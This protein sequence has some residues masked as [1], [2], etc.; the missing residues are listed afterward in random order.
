[1]HPLS[2]IFIKKMLKAGVHLNV[3][4][5]PLNMGLTEIS[6]S[7]FKQC[8]NPMLKF[9]GMFCKFLGDFRIFLGG[10]S[11]FQRIVTIRSNKKFED[12]M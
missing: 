2:R 3:V 4:F 6:R 8:R 7:R 1:M 9:R 11:V 10:D 5:P 12:L